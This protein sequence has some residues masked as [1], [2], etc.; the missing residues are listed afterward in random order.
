MTAPAVERPSPPVGLG[1]DSAPPEQMRPAAGGAAD[2]HAQA[3]ASMY[4]R[5]LALHRW[6][7]D[8]DARALAGQLLLFAMQPEDFLE[9]PEELA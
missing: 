6:H 5:G 4:A 1:R 3:L 2:Q 7:R 9:D 8:R